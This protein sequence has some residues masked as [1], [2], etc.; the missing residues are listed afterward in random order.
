MY[1]IALDGPSGAGKSTLA[2]AIAKRLG[3]IHVDTGA[4]Y[5]AIG[6]YILRQG[7]DTVNPN[8]VVPLLPEI[9]I[10]LGFER[11]QQQIFLG[12]E[13]ISQAIRM[14]E[15]AMAASNV[16]AI[17]QVRTFLLEKQRELARNNSVIMDGRDIATVVLPDATVKIFL[18][19]TPE[20]RARRRWLELVD[21]GHNL[22]YEAVLADVEKR[23]YND[24]HRETAPLCQA[25]GAVL[26]DTTQ[27][28]FEQSL[29]LLLSIIRDRV[30][31]I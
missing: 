1:S 9:V 16:S 15:A 7:K 31:D 26:A 10:S 17:P 8:H 29:A 11:E 14:P 18:T 20:A 4:M 30:V 21:K 2:Q 25:P 6:L 24:S 28:N 5:R 27:L 3:I 13:D 23:D 12:G 22:T 19:A